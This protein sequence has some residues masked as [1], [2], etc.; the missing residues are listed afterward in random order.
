KKFPPETFNEDLPRFDI[1]SKELRQSVVNINVVVDQGK[2]DEKEVP[3]FKDLPSS[4]SDVSLGSGFIVSKDGY[5]VTNRH[6][7][8]DAKKILIRF[9]DN[10]TDYEAKL[11]GMDDKTDIALIKV[12]LDFDLLPLHLGDSDKME[13]GDWVLAIGNQFQLGQ[14]VTAGIVSA[15]SRKIPSKNNASINP[16]SSGGPLINSLGQVIGINTAIF[17]P[18]RGQLGGAGFN[19]GIGFAIPSN[20]S[21][22]IINQLKE[23]GRVVRGLLGVLIQE[24]DKDMAEV[25]GIQTA[26]GAL[27][28]DVTKGG[29]AD[30]IGI[31][32]KDVIVKFNNHVIREHDDLPLLVANTDVDTKVSV[33]LIRDKQLQTFWPIIAKMSD[34]AFVPEPVEPEVKANK[35]G[36]VLQDVSKEIAKSFNMRKARGVIV[37]Q[38]E[39]DSVGY[40]AGLARGDIIL[41]IDHR[42]VKNLSEFNEIL[43]SL[44][45][46]KPYL[47]TIRKKDGT[48]FS[49]LKIE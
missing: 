45:L 34:K 3:F 18:G 17:S 36:L 46:N 11:I 25:L 1:L 37:T 20:D 22:K 40:K 7:V 27:V 8:A 16:G 44:L 23:S 10:R 42:N 12:D 2:K 32:P 15:K 5:I 29:P 28:A 13:V 31:K 19:I 33:E 47:V 14:T 26:Y 48:R 24:V 30:K 6:V 38:V 4:R 49:T 21:V 41:E 39:A 35:I 9:Y 43:D